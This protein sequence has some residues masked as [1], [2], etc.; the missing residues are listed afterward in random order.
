MRGGSRPFLLAACLI[1][2]DEC[3]PRGMRTVTGSV[4]VLNRMLGRVLSFCVD[5]SFDSQQER[6]RLR[7]AEVASQVLAL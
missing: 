3:L 5:S 1:R 6:V 7:K 4:C 2:A